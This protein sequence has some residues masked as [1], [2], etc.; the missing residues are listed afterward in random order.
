[1][2]RTRLISGLII[3]VSIAVF[4][5]VGGPALLA[6]LLLVSIRGMFEFYRA[7]GVLTDKRRIDPATGIA[8]VFCIAY[9]AALYV[10]DRNMF[11]PVFVMVVFL[12]VLLGAY[13]F[14]FPK[15]NAKDI[16]FTFFGFF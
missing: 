10:S 6:L 14:T 4:T 11:Y 12:L 16:V 8:Y 5:N 9:Y 3:T 2:F 15:Y 1:M 7:T 13:V